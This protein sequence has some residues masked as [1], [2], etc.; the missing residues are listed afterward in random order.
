M[1]R[2]KQS[3]QTQEV[4]KKKIDQLT[5]EEVHL[6]EY[7]TC[8]CKNVIRKDFGTGEYYC[9]DCFNYCHVCRKFCNNLKKKDLGIFDKAKKKKKWKFKRKPAPKP[10]ALGQNAK[11][12]PYK[13]TSSKI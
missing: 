4:K 10:P 5:S 7:P 6:Q 9:Y 13:K 3:E 8:L 2:N 1:A 11:I 12:I